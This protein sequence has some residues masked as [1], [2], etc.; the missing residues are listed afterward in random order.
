[1]KCHFHGVS[2]TV[3]LPR[4]SWLISELAGWWRDI[5]GM[6]MHHLNGMKVD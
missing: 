6:P 5:E 3:V 1:M 4:A 2:P